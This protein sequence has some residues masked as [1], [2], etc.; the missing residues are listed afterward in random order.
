MDQTDHKTA[1]NSPEQ[2]GRATSSKGFNSEL[3]KLFQEAEETID[4]IIQQ[5]KE[6]RDEGGF[7]PPESAGEEPAAPPSPPP[8]ELLQWQDR[9]T[10]LESEYQKVRI[11]YQHLEQDFQNYRDRMER[12]LAQ[13]AQQ[14]QAE[15]LKQLLEVLDVIN[16][17]RNTF[18]SEKF[19]HTVENY[20]KGFNLLH[21]KF[22][23]VLSQMGLK[24]IEAVGM[25]FDPNLHQ[26]VA[27]EE[28]DDCEI[29]TII[30]EI[31]AGYQYQD[32]LLRPAMVRVAVPARKK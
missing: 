6:P 8:D 13:A 17:A 21:G 9:Y 11:L 23:T 27:M 4:R 32:I 28:S 3:E 10:Q 7:P 31:T 25:E 14:H 5:K 15:L 22:F 12:T 29:Q 19:G 16:L 30:K 26:A 20:Q 24:K 1:N 2:S 18:N